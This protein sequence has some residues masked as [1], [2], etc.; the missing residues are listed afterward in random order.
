MFFLPSRADILVIILTINYLLPFL[1]ASSCSDVTASL[2]A[3]HT[4]CSDLVALAIAITSPVALLCSALSG[5]PSA[6]FGPQDES[7][8]QEY[9]PLEQFG[10]CQHQLE[11]TREDGWAIFGKLVASPFLNWP[12]LLEVSLIQ[13]ATAFS[14]QKQPL[15]L[16][17]SCRGTDCF[18]SQCLDCVVEC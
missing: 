14:C 17:L 10:L 4:C 8:W 5:Q 6:R 11:A 7:V 1:Q 13:P 16:S 18:H 15:I 12:L 2:T 9:I 3:V